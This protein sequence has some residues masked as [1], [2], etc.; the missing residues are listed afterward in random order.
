MSYLDNGIIRLG[1][2]LNLGGA[3]TYLSKS[4]SDQNI[5][6]SFDFGRQIQMSYYSGPVPFTPDG[7]QPKPEWNFIGWNPIQVGDAFG[8]AS[9]LLEEKH[10]GKSLYVKCVPMH[11][12]LDNVPGECTYECWLELEGAAV[13]AR[14]RLVNHRADHTQ[15]P[16]RD[17]ELPAV[18]TNAPFHRLMT[19]TRDKPFTGPVTHIFKGKDE[20]NGYTEAILHA[21]RREL[22]AMPGG[23]RP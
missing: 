6:N 2:D 5:V 1:V 12:P 7:K 11:W 9:K 14:C 20:P 17:Q 21:R 19:A 3:I 13:H 8:N 10:D 18:Y 16:A 4:G 22:K 15:Y 23:A